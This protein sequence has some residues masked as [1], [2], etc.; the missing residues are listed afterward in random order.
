[1]PRHGLGFP[2]S[3]DRLLVG[4]NTFPTSADTFSVGADMFPV[5]ADTFLASANTFY[6]ALTCSMGRRPLN[7]I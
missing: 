5:G 7:W 2:A 3:S 6:R 4:A 1:M